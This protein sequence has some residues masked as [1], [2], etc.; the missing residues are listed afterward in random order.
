MLKHVAQLDGRCEPSDL[1]EWN[2]GVF[3]QIPTA[4]SHAL[5]SIFSGAGPQ[6]WNAIREV[7][8]VLLDKRVRN[9][10]QRID[11]RRETRYE[12]L[13]CDLIRFVEK[14]SPG[15]WWDVTAYESEESRP[16]DDWRLGSLYAGLTVLCRDMHLFLN[17]QP[18]CGI[19]KLPLFDD[20]IAE[21]RSDQSLAGE[22]GFPNFTKEE[23]ELLPRGLAAEL[24]RERVTVVA[25]D[26]EL[27]RD[28]ELLKK[29]DIVYE[30]TII[31]GKKL[32]IS[33]MRTSKSRLETALADERRFFEEA[34]IG[35]KE[36][37]FALFEA[38]LQKCLRDDHPF[39]YPLAV[40]LGFL[41]DQTG[42][43][44]SY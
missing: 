38:I 31:P 28:L 33:F 30:W 6:D 16:E 44:K 2:K 41:I 3:L 21:V 27:C 8:K 29:P 39:W 15:S 22:I 43:R 1:K 13:L 5:D 34:R 18:A 11:G 20:V 42:F 7:A 19:E 40:Y 10:Q 25:G 35:K 24:C 37:P 4:A 17:E 23:A 36:I 32:F 26:E 14:I 9:H 12:P